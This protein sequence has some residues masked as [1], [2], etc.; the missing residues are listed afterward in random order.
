MTVQKSA[1]FRAA[2]CY[3]P[4]PPITGR[5]SLFLNSFTHSDYSTHFC[6]PAATRRRDGLILFHLNL[7]SVR[8]HQLRRRFNIHDGPV[9][10]GNSWPHT[11]MVQ[12]CQHFRLV[13]PHDVIQKFK[14][15]GRN[16]SHLAP[17]HHSAGTFRFVSRPLVPINR[18][19][20]CLQNLTP[21]RYK[22][23]MSG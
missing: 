21:S 12:A 3:K 23:R 20:H 5:P 15:I 16:R 19:L 4:N 9:L 14:Y 8:T 11:F 6:R 22:L 18:L 1:S 10:K 13:K 17:H 2:W 7:L